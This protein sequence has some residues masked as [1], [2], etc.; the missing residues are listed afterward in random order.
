MH[1]ALRHSFFYARQEEDPEMTFTD[2]Q[3]RPTLGTSATIVYSAPGNILNNTGGDT[4]D[5]LLSGAF[6]EFHAFSFVGTSGSH[7]RISNVDGDVIIGS[8]ANHLF[9]R[10]GTN[11]D[12]FEINGKSASEPMYF[13]DVGDV[14]A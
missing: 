12:Y 5:K 9:T 3:A 6:T 13:E 4:Q 11:S 10:E 8:V 7:R 1:P 14:A 2:I